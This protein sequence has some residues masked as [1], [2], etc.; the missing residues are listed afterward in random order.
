MTDRSM[1]MII[2]NAVQSG[3][4]LENVFEAVDSYENNYG[5]CRVE[6]RM[7]EH[8]MPERPLE[9]KISA[10]GEDEAQIQLLAAAMA[11]AI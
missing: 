4:K 5:W 6:P 2:R 1:K 10:G 7:N 8:L 3:Q 11:R 9:I